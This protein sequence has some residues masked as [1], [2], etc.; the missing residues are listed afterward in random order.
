MGRPTKR[1]KN[2]KGQQSRM[3]PKA[4]SSGWLRQYLTNPFRFENKI[5]TA[6]VIIFLVINGLVLVNAVLHP[7]EV[8]YDAPQHLKYIKVLSQSRLP[9]P[10]DTNQFYAPPLP[11]ALP[12]L[13]LSLGLLSFEAVAKF[14]QLLNAL[15]SM[16]LTFYLIK[17]CQLARPGDALFAITSLALAGMLPVYY[18]TMAFVRGEP[19]LTLIAVFSVYKTLTIVVKNDRRASQMIGLGISLGLLILTRQMGF[20]VL[21]AVVLFIVILALRS[22][23]KRGISFKAS[24]SII[25]MALVVGGWFY[26]YHFK[27]YGT[28]AVFNRSPSPAFAISNQPREFYIGLGLDKLFS[29]PIRRSFPNQFLPIFYSEVWGDYWCDFLVYGRISKHGRFLSGGLLDANLSQDPPPW[30]HTNRFEISTYL[31]RVNLVSLFPSAVY[32]AGVLLGMV[33][34]VRFISN[35]FAD[36]RS[37]V[38]SLLAMVIALSGI[39]YFCFL[40]RYPSPLKGDTI[41]ATYLLHIFPFVSILASEIL[42]RIKR[43]SAYGYLG[44][45]IMLFVTLLHNFPVFVTHYTSWHYVLHFANS[46]TFPLVAHPSTSPSPLGGEGRDEG[47]TRSRQGL[48]KY[49]S[50]LT[51]WSTKFSSIYLPPFGFSLDL[52]NCWCL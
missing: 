39:G 46:I 43:R 26:I 24:A 36:E 33:G 20:F 3:G 5:N 22:E 48:E 13:L 15:Y 47:A 11:Y 8:G 29:D 25:L 38:Y 31:G 51:K 44:A 1:M 10:N 17:I 19:L 35:P 32:L 45:M 42:Q 23:E 30:L 28:V 4:D 34:L 41:K 18:K 12:A 14:S 27:Q 2:P 37:A 21:G 9:T 16:L 52:R 7:A 50:V 40:I 6:L 49:V